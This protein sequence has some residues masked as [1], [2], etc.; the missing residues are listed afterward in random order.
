[1]ERPELPLDGY[2]DLANRAQ[3]TDSAIANRDG[4]VWEVKQEEFI[5]ACMKQAGFIYYPREVKPLAA[6]ESS[7]GLTPAGRRLWVPWLPDD[8]VD[9]ERY[10]YSY[11]KPI[12]VIGNTPV[13]DPSVRDPNE[14][15]VASLSAPARK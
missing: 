12:E 8:L 2:G 10:G 1:M 15:Y 13:A 4:G 11:S 3:E 9:A 7:T 6:G 5:A 14:E